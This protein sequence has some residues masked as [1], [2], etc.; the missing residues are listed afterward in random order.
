[1][2]AAARKV[3]E[4]SQRLDSSTDRL[5]KWGN[6]ARMSMKTKNR[7]SADLQVSKA[8]QNADLKVGATRNV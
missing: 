4:G 5:Q 6:K 1:M 2:R 3:A 8:G 7:R